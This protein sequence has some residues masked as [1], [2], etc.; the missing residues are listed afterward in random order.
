MAA[1]TVGV[2]IA[3][4]IGMD[5]PAFAVSALLADSMAA[6]AAPSKVVVEAFTAVV[7]ASMVVVAASMVV[8]AVVAG[9]D[10][11]DSRV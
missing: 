3:A 9:I 11:Q 8:V 10:K 6:M 2:V 1:A 4:G 7:A 5:R